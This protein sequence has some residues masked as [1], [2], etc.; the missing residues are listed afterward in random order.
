MIACRSWNLN[1]NNVVPSEKLY[2]SEEVTRPFLIRGL[3][4]PENPVQHIELI[5]VD[6][7]TMVNGRK[8][9]AERCFPVGE[10]ILELLQVKR[11][12]WVDICLPE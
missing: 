3:V 2:S 11:P 7:F 8:D 9:Q 6:R 1:G 4:L 5:V 10:T 12:C